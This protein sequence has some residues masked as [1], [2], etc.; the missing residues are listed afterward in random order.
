[1]KPFLPVLASA[2]ALLAAGTAPGA[3]IVSS[4]L[5]N[6]ETDITGGGGIFAGAAGGDASAAVGGVT[7]TVVANP[8]SKNGKLATDS[9]GPMTTTLRAVSAADGLDVTYDVTFSPF[10]YDGTS[11]VA[12]SSRIG[13]FV[14]AS[15]ANSNAEREQT[16]SNADGTE[17]FRVTIDNVV[18]NGATTWFLDGAVALRFNGLS[19][20]SVRDTYVNGVAGTVLGTGGTGTSVSGDSDVALTSPAASFAIVATADDLTGPRANFE[21]RWE[22]LAVQF[23][24]VPEPGSLALLGVAGLFV[25]ARRRRD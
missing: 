3:T 1:M 7:T 21:N 16:T 23:T 25:A 8:G 13:G 5:D 9:L 18:N 4:A 17:F 14:S 15:Y 11:D 19:G 10:L 22:G 24:D 20:I 6:T 2:A 12:T